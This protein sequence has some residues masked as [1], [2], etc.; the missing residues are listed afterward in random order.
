MMSDSEDANETLFYIQDI[1]TSGDENINRM[2]GNALLH[3]AY[4]PIVVRSLCS[5][6][7]KPILSLNTCIYVLI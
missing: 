1:F 2:L 3:Y 5:M 6:R 4:M 7:L